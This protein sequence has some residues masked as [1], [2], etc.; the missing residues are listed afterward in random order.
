MLSIQAV[1]LAN[2]HAPPA[3]L[4]SNPGSRCMSSEQAVSMHASC[5]DEACT[6]QMSADVRCSNKHAD[7]WRATAPVTGTRVVIRGVGGSHLV[8]LAVGVDVQ[9]DSL[10]APCQVGYVIEMLVHVHVRP[11]RYLHRPRYLQSPR[12][13]TQQGAGRHEELLGMT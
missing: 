3:G 11:P 9:G 10:Q 5:I 7:T 2:E 12:P 8:Q 13:A 1:D 6:A 4:Y